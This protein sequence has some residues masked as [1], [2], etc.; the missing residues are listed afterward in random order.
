L[1]YLSQVPDIAAAVAPR[2]HTSS[3]IFP[4]QQFR[5][6]AANRAVRSGN[7][8]AMGIP[9]FPMRPVDN[10]SLAIAGQDHT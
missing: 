9:T 10:G 5:N 1:Q 2:Q 7:Q 3:M 4:Q 6:V 8:N